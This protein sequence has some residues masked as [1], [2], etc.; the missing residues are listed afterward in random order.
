MK[1][2]TQLNLFQSQLRGQ[3]L[4]PSNAA[5]EQARAVYNGM[6]DKRPALIAQCVDVAD[7][8]A[9]VN[10]VWEAGMIVAI[11]GGGHNG[12]GLGTVYGGP[13]IWPLE[14]SSELLEI[15]RDFILQAPED[16][17][18]WFAFMTVSPVAPFPEKFHLKKMCAVVWCDVCTKESAEKRFTAIRK[19]FGEPAIDLVGP[20]PWPTLQSLFDSFFPS[21]LQW[22]WKADF[23]NELTSQAIA[24][25]NKYGSELPTA[26][27][28]MHIYPI[29]GAVH[30]INK[31]DTAFSF[32]D[33]NF[34][35]VIAA[36]GSDPA[37]NAKMIAWA[38][39]YWQDIHP[40][41]AGGAYINM[42]MDEGQDNVKAAYRENYNRL[43]EIKKKY[44]MANLFR[45]NQNISPS[46]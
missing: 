20:I 13:M 1:A 36:I 26:L 6:I 7:V 33:A 31:N 32:R 27:S 11:R 10:F 30:R 44:D 3:L 16:I 23:F 12:P 34:A 18:G 46:S 19:Q 4:N 28:T 37:D 41:S 21:G 14:R 9:A 15:W 29:N 17:N 22:Y 25:H 35:E 42:I 8:M 2:N 24:L 45:V 5:Y 39:K 43:V 40:Y 38:R